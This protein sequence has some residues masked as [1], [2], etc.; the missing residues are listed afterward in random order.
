MEYTNIITK[1]REFRIRRPQTKAK[2]DGEE[3]VLSLKYHAERQKIRNEK[4]RA[5]LAID[6]EEDAFLQAYRNQ[7]K[8]EKQE[9]QAE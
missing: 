8:Q 6:M 1:Q 2:Y 7:K 5:L 3:S 9:E 4:E